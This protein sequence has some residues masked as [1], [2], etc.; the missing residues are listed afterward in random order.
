MKITEKK[1][2]ELRERL[3]ENYDSYNCGLAEMIIDDFIDEIEEYDGDANLQD[4]VDDITGNYNG[5]YTCSTFE[6]AK[7][8]AENIFEFNEIAEEMEENGYGKFEITETEINLVK[9]LCYICNNTILA[10]D[11]DTLEELIE[12]L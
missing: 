8:I 5:S 9:V 3:L 10:Q 2:E 6:S 12:S 7:I 11:C 1:K 4:I